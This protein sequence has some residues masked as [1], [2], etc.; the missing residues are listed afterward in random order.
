MIVTKGHQGIIM[1]VFSCN[2][3]IP[4]GTPNPETNSVRILSFIQNVNHWE[5]F[6]VNS[7]NFKVQLH[8]QKH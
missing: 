1:L 4:M 5:I 7:P 8:S 3:D 2:L 6:K